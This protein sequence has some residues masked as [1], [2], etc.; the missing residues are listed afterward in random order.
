ML[1]ESEN[2][3]RNAGNKMNLSNLKKKNVSA[4]KMPQ[5]WWKAL[6]KIQRE[7]CASQP[8]TTIIYLIYRSDWST[9]LEICFQGL[10]Q[11]PCQYKRSWSVPVST[12]GWTQ[13]NTGLPVWLRWAVC[14]NLMSDSFSLLVKPHFS[15]SIWIL[16]N[17]FVWHIVSLKR[18]RPQ[19]FK[20]PWHFHKLSTDLSSSLFSHRAPCSQRPFCF[21]SIIQST[22]SFTLRR[23]LSV[24]Q[25]FL[26]RKFIQCEC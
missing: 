20:P 26:T 19:V 7:T 15:S 12:A 16:S 6:E 14:I 21:Y 9:L 18:L 24:V 11:V 13:G 22:L 25:C 1:F 8:T 2:K 23:T 10:F 4:E 5:K 17:F 3:L